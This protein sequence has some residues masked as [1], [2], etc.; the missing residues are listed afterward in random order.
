MEWLLPSSTIPKS[1]CTC[2][3]LKHFF[4]KVDLLLNG[5][6]NVVVTSFCCW[7]S[8]GD[9]NVDFDSAGMLELFSLRLV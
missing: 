6:L 3:I 1:I 9:D 8:C 7:M 5:V 4:W 2:Y